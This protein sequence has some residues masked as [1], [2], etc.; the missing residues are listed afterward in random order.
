M[1]HLH[2]EYNQFLSHDTQRLSE[3]KKS[4]R[5]MAFLR[6]AAF[7][8][9]ILSLI[10]LPKISLLLAWASALL[11]LILFFYG[12]KSF[13]LK[14][15][16]KK[17]YTRLL[18]I[19]QDEQLALEEIFDQFDNGAEYTDPDHSY[20]FDLDLF[21]TGSLFQYLNRTTTS[22]GK[23][24]LAAYLNHPILDPD[25]IELR[26]KAILELS[27]NTRWRHYFAAKGP[28]PRDQQLRFMKQPGNRASLENASSLK[29]IFT[30]FPSISVLLL[31]LCIFSLLPWA[32]FMLSGSA[33]LLI[34]FIH[35]R[36]IDAFYQL[37]G[38]QTGILEN[39][40]ELLRLIEEKQFR[41]ELLK[42]IQNSLSVDTKTASQAIADLKQIM[43]RFEYRSNVIFILTGE[44]IFLWDL[45]C[46]YKLNLWQQKYQNH[47][48]SWFDAIYE[49]DAL[50]S[51]ANLNH[52]H[53]EW[54]LPLF[55]RTT[56]CFSAGDLGH[57]LIK[58]AKRIGNDFIMNGEGKIIIITGANMAG[59]S[60]FLRTIGI[61]MILAMNGCRVC[62][63]RMT[64]KPVNLFTNMR[65]TDN[66]RKEESYFF[67]E[68]Q[69]L[70][71]MFN[72][73]LAGQPL[74]VIIDE[75]LKGTNS[76]DKLSGS[77]ALVEKLIRL[78]GNAVIATHDLNLTALEE[79]YPEII[80]NN[81][82]DV[83]LSSE[84]LIFDY[85]LR[86]GVTRTMNASFLMKKMG[87]ID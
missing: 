18:K 45:I 44:F 43:S 24:K 86:E 60:T 76:S 25:I 59:K 27:E 33:N 38:N 10:F 9:M 71:Q 34:L 28:G 49:L 82:F 83:Q 3:A 54:A 42:R 29:W 51:L 55:E 17:F 4:I 22:G 53:Q 69:R 8:G 50:S 57:P 62:A 36:K 19:N 79:T 41:S 7:S 48:G 6:L 16:E 47:I 65:T 58:P 80:V 61:N 1:N 66:L 81:C 40:P 72:L 35:R 2:Q 14:E 56:F 68:L 74:F 37:F 64:M 26:Q 39:Y 63:T 21:G 12:I 23:E 70:Q 20:S 77:K 46:V 85:K 75:M 87:I 67:A 31:I 78:H 15:K 5:T 73:L 32:A 13:I 11:L 52:N 84:N 30:V